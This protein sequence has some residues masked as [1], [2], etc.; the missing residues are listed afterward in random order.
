MSY[1]IKSALQ[2]FTAALG[3][4]LLSLQSMNAVANDRDE[5]SRKAKRIQGVTMTGTNSA[6]GKPVFSW[7]GVFGTFNFPTTFVYNS[8]GTEPLPL[9]ETTPASAILATGVSPEYLFI[10]GETP[11]VVKP[12]WINVPLRKVPVNID[13]DVS[14]T[15]KTVL[16]GLLQADPVERSQSEPAGDIT[17]GQWMKANGVLT[18]NC[19]GR[20]ADL[21]MRF[22]NLIPNRL[23]SVWATMGLPDPGSG[24][25]NPAIPLPIGGTPSVFMTDERGDATF[26]R[27]IKFCPLDKNATRD[28]MLTIEVLYHANHSVYGAIPAPGIMLGLITFPHV[29]FPINVELLAN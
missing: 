19:A 2:C 15:K 6:L 25:E 12:E 8:H 11:D 13:F 27:W 20:G 3:L 4:G 9:D 23:Y 14:L 16:R 10:R 17:L 29:L 24:I 5:S 22:E 7:G 28:P 18:I 21:K 1:Q 26:R